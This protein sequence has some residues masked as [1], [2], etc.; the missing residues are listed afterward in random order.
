L[1]QISLSNLPTVTDPKD[2]AL[3]EKLVRNVNLPEYNVEVDSEVFQGHAIVT[4]QAGEQNVQRSLLMI[5]FKL[6]QYMRNYL[7]LYT[8]MQNIRYGSNIVGLARK[9][10]VSTLSVKILDNNKRLFGWFDYTN[11]L[12]VGLSA[13]PFNLGVGAEIEFTTSWQYEQALF[14]YADPSPEPS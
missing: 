12:C 10:V 2:M 8:W 4:P 5:N 7:L 14:Q 6:S 11:A 9:N 3:F 13:L 1:W